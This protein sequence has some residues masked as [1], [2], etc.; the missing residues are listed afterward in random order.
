M[1]EMSKKRKVQVRPEDEGGLLSRVSDPEI[2]KQLLLDQLDYIEAM[3]TGRTGDM[4]KC[5]SCE[6]YYY[7]DDDEYFEVAYSCFECQMQYCGQ[8]YCNGKRT[9]LFPD[10]DDS[11]TV[12]VECVEAA[13][14]NWAAALN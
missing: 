7:G 8:S 14:I 3:E 11:F 6:I 2:L 1:S 10:D 5:D 4:S 9:L 13:K 12:C